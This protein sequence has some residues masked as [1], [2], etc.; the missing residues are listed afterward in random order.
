MSTTDQTLV[1][2]A[3]RA[4]SGLRIALSALTFAVVSSQAWP[5]AT[6]TLTHWGDLEKDGFVVA[7]TDKGT[8]YLSVYLL[9]R[10]MNQLPVH[11]DF[12]DHL[13]VVHAIDT[14]E[15]VNIQRMQFWVRGWFWD[16]KFQYEFQS[17]S[18]LSTTQVALI[19]QIGYAFAKQAKLTIGVSGNPGVR[20]LL[21]QAPLFFGT[22]RFLGDEYFKPGFTSG[23]WLTGEL[24]PGLQYKLMSGN[25]LS[26]L[27][28]TAVQLRRNKA[29]SATGWWM[30][31]TK[32]FGPRGAYGDYEDH[33]KLAVR[34]GASFTHSRE[35]RLNQIPESSPDNTVI[36]LSDS[37]LLFATGS[38]APDVTVINA[39]YRL[40][41]ADLGFKYRG[42]HVQGD[43]YYRS[44][45]G[46]DADGPV[47]MT[48]ILDK[49][50]EIQTGYMV[51]PKRF[52]LYASTS[53]ITGAF[54]RPHEVAGGANYYP[55]TGRYPKLDFWMTSVSRS[56]VSSTFGY[57]VGGQKGLTF[58]FSTD[59]LF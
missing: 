21:G 7:K 3:R 25:A 4:G 9:G 16:P 8:L 27:G 1:D 45:S 29:S 44:L 5:Q 53:Q 31:T 52:E 17:W 38:L 48:K 18:V 30:P 2:K 58:S 41:S 46:F 37:D 32:E 42:L 15:D 55:G 51:V 50:Y 34:I 39:S 59:L 11:Q 6:D 23:A 36:R 56:P 28:I 24:V 26:Q 54:N 47:P 20:S 33:Q 40:T 12:T 35:N 14:R 10:Y 43:Y 13:G 19:G 22:D 57:Y 49:G